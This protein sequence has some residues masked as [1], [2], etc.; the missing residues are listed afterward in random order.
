MLMV[1]L[2]VSSVICSLQPITCLRLNSSQ[3]LLL[4]HRQPSHPLSRHP[5]ISH[6][7]CRYTALHFLFNFHSLSLFY[8]L[9]LCASLFWGKF[10]GKCKQFK[11]LCWICHNKKVPSSSH[12]AKMWTAR[13]R[14]L[15]KNC[16]WTII[17]GSDT[18]VWD[19]CG[20]IQ[21]EKKHVKQ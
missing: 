19:L 5:Y 8:T 1:G 11:P 9:C 4:S 15:F 12:D 13:W 10:Y 18:L 17:S 20:E 2:C 21:P 7:K 14:G 3:Y 16:Q 6:T